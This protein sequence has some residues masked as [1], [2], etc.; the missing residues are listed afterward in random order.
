MS[1]EMTELKEDNEKLKKLCL[2]LNA[3]LTNSNLSDNNNKPFGTPI[4]ESELEQLLEEKS[5]TIRKLHTE[6]LEYQ[7]IITELEDRLYGPGGT[8]FAN[9][10]PVQTEGSNNISASIGELESKKDI[11][12]REIRLMEMQ[13]CDEE[14]RA[15]RERAELARQKYDLERLR[16]D[17]EIEIE[18]HAKDSSLKTKI[19]SLKSRLHDAGTEP[20][21][22]LKN[23]S[24]ATEPVTPP[25]P[26]KSIFGKLFGGK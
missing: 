24:E 15:S 1:D 20:L 25:T 22:G 14:I 10:K 19:D 7:K 2:E 8:D 17:L 9:E 5:E 11:L 18:K 26:T 21:R 4:P 3:A 12:G 16:S 23:E 6:N 13:L